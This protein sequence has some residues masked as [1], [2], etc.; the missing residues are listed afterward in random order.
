MKVSIALTTYNGAAY[1]Q[2]QLN[3]YL[4]QERL[5]DELVVCDDV[6]TDETV[7]ILEAFKKTAPFQVRVIINELNLGFTKNFE[8]ALLNCS[9]DLVFLSD[10]DDVWYPEKILVV[11]KAFLQNPDKYLLIH[12][13]D[14]V[15]ENLVS[16]GATKRGQ[17][18]KG[19]GSDKHLITGALTVIHK[20]LIQYSL[21]IPTKIIGHDGWLHS[22]AKLLNKRLVIDQSLQQIRRHTKNTSD[23]IASSVRPI[24]KFSVLRSQLSSKASNS[25]QDRLKYN[26]SLVLR[27]RELAS[28]EYV[29]ISIVVISAS[30]KQLEKEHKAIIHREELFQLS[31][32]NKRIKAIRMLVGGD[33]AY[34][35]GSKSFLRDMF[36]Y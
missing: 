12:D 17:V 13:G 36:R 8:K 35:N 29:D 1:L 25:Y 9:G 16:H 24:N 15:D 27:L 7:T 19:Y 5:P 2:A 23:W 3:S 10:Q 20:N 26:L 21:P 31:F 14:L 34:F 18:V 33:Y 30:L 28:I 4:V 22:M 32:I 6:S 11:V